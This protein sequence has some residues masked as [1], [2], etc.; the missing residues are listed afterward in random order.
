MFFCLMQVSATIYSQTTKFT[1]KADNKQIVDVLRE[2]EGNSNFRFFYLRE[3]VDVERR[4]SIT[5][6]D[7][8]VEQILDELFKG[9]EISYEL[10]NDFLIVLSKGDNK[11]RDLGANSSGY[12]Q[13]RTVNGKVTDTSGQPLPGVSIVIKGTTQGTVTNTSGEYTLTNLPVNAILDF[14]FVGMATVE[15]QVNNQTTIDVIMQEQAIGLEEV[16]AV[17][18]GVQKK[19]NVIG[20]VESVTSEELTLNPVSNVS[21]TL[22]GRLPGAIVLQESGEPGNNDARILIRGIATLGDASPLIVV[23]GIP[24]RDLNSIDPW[25]IE[26]LTILKDASAAIYGARSA[27]GVILVTTKRGTGGVPTFKYEFFEGIKQPTVVPELLNSYQYAV[28]KREGE[29]D[30]GIPENS[31]TFSLEDIEKYKEGLSGEYPWA[32]PNTN[33][34]DATYKEWSNIRHHTFSVNG[35]SNNSRYYVSFGTQYENGLEKKSAF[36][37]NRYNLKAN[38]DFDLNKYINV[39]LDLSGVVQD[40][41]AGSQGTLA[42]MYGVVLTDPTNVAIFPNGLP[43]PDRTL[44]WNPVI[45]ATDATGFEDDN[46]YRLY[47]KINAKI[48]VPR[49]ENLS[50]STYYSYDLYFNINK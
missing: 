42:T 37:Y 7:A 9:R 17:G 8:T 12:F 21:N 26:S 24:G 22:A 2:I 38:L 28:R 30:Q 33:W 6:N 20:S 25:D 23:D 3:Q 31:M 14:S 32:Y 29:I 44:G 5:A 50:I 35:G 39:G 1:F 46:V 11:L 49:I 47:S 4:V 40:K 19:V 41:G 18:Y 27:N 16:V 43:G 48:K 15:I 45:A 13:Q 34:W 10:M 36:K